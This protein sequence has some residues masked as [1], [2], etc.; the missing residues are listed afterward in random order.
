[1]SVKVTKEI[2]NAIRCLI[3][4]CGSALEVERKTKI[5]NVSIGR[6]LSADPPRMNDST[7]AVLEPYLRPYLPHESVTAGV[8]G[9]GRNYGPVI[10]NAESV[11]HR[12]VGATPEELAACRASA[13]AGALDEVLDAVMESDIDDAAKIRFYGILKQLKQERK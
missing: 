13:R 8:I 3:D 6:Y 12:T 7:W 1:M 9:S 5:S 10:G 11:V 4:N 2:Q